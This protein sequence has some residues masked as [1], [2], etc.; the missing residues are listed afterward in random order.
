MKKRILYIVGGIA[1]LLVIAYY[2]APF[3]GTYMAARD[4]YEAWQEV[5]QNE[6]VQARSAT[7][8]FPEPLGYVSDFEKVFTSIQTEKLEKRLANYEQETTRE[9]AVVTIASLAPYEDINDYAK[10]LGNEWGVGKADS[11]NG[12][13][14]VLCKELRM[15]RIST[16]YGT[17]NVLTDSICQ[18]VIDKTM[19]PYFRE[20]NY[21]DGIEVALDELLQHW[22]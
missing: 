7:K 17:E 20:G 21:Y 5:E 10:D 18:A 1:I 22:K 14:I 4:S 16:G 12:L 11:D 15:V 6:S 9:I 19:L 3:I 8:M 2:S 13:L